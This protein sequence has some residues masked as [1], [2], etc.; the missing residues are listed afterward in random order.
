MTRQRCG[1]VD[2]PP[3][4]DTRQT[5]KGG[6]ALYEPEAAVPNGWKLSDSGEKSKPQEPEQ[7]AVRSSAWLGT[8]SQE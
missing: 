7:Y 6:R 2:S 3:P 8:C 4:A 1:R 5:L